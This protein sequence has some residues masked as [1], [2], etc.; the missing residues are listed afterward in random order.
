MQFDK[1]INRIKFKFLEIS[2]YKHINYF[3][4]YILNENNYRVFYIIFRKFWVY[5]LVLLWEY[6]V[7]RSII[8]K[9]WYW[10]VINK[11]TYVCD[12]HITLYILPSTSFI[13]SN[14]YSLI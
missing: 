7:T 3:E 5:Y 1:L 2:Y 8:R 11:F 10:V 14:N 6:D 9:I 12:N 13:G 4:T